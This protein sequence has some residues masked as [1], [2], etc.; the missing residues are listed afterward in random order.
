MQLGS[1]MHTLLF[2]DI[3]V[4]YKKFSVASDFSYLSSVYVHF[5]NLYQ[6]LANF[7]DKRVIGF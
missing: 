1:F 4:I 7:H 5:R 3:F 6:W 2:S